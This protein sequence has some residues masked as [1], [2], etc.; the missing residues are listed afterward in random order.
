MKYLFVVL[1]LFMT[2]CHFNP[3]YKIG[4]CYALEEYKTVAII[5]QIN[6]F[7]IILKGKNGTGYVSNGT[8]I[9]SVPDSFCEG[10][11]ETK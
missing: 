5:V 3:K 4:Q 8:G 9:Y 2:G 10:I 1:G 11:R 7:S 6:S